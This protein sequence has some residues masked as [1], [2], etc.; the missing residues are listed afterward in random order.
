M[1]DMQQS[2]VLETVKLLEMAVEEGFPIWPNKY[3]ILKTEEIMQLIDR[4]YASIPIEIKEAR[5]FLDRIEQVKLAAQ[6]EAEKMI[7]DAQMEADRKLSEADFIKAVEREGI[8]IRNQ[9]QEECEELKRKAVEEAD[10]IRSQA[11]EDAFKTKEGAELYVE[12]VL[13]NLESDLTK[14]KQ[15]V[16]NGQIYLEQ[17]RKESGSASSIY[18][19]QEVK[20][21]PDYVMK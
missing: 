10:S 21:T 15:V 3:V 6:Q 2:G 4:I 20:R 12:Q 16:K 7:A 1:S 19:G 14:L 11:A 18:P 13:T 17:S 8:R 5:D 9:V